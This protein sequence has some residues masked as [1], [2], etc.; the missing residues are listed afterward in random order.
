M[1]T[2]SG[3]NRVDAVESKLGFILGSLGDLKERMEMY[4]NKRPCNDSTQTVAVTTSERES[5]TEFRKNITERGIQI[6]PDVAEIGTQTAPVNN[7]GKKLMEKMSQVILPALAAV[8]MEWLNEAIRENIVKNEAAGASL[9]NILLKKF[10]SDD[11]VIAMH[12]CIEIVKATYDDNNESESGTE[13]ESEYD[14]AE[15]EGH[16][17]PSPT[18]FQQQQRQQQA[19]GVSLYYKVRNGM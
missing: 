11:V 9:Q 3:G 14:T 18:P 10:T 16:V 13:Y 15:S 8:K 12:A 2:E 4:E 1:S 5:Q 19:P 6:T 17:S 7:V